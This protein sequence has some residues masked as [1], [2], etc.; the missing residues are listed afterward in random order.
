[1]EGGLREHFCL[2]RRRLAVEEDEEEEEQ[3]H[4]SELASQRIVVSG[5]G[6]FQLPSAVRQSWTMSSAELDNGRSRKG[7]SKP[8]RL[9]LRN[10]AEAYTGAYAKLT[11]ALC[12]K[13]PNIP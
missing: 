7:F 8:A 2:S 12:G 10:A 11:R 4:C 6:P 13:R 9:L 5:V 3:L 1:M